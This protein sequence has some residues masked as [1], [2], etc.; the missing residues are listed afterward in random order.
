MCGKVKKELQKKPIQ[1]Q[2][3]HDDDNEKKAKRIYT[4]FFSALYFRVLYKTLLYILRRIRRTQNTLNVYFF[5]LT[6]YI[7]HF[8]VRT[9]VRSLGYYSS[10]FFISFHTTCPILYIF[11]SLFTVHIYFIL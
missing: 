11:H 4:S 5:L 1:R 6:A 7:S 10:F 9:N 8:C 3:N 2:Q